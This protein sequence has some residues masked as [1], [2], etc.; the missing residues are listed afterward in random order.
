[1]WSLWLCPKVIDHIKQP[2]LYWLI[3]FSV[4]T[5]YASHLL[6]KTADSCQIWSTNFNRATKP[7][8]RLTSKTFLSTISNRK[9]WESF[10]CPI[11]RRITIFAV[12]SFPVATRDVRHLF[13]CRK[14]VDK[15]NLRRQLKNFRSSKCISFKIL[16]LVKSNLQFR[17]KI[18]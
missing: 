14:F 16:V 7:K 1:M 17:F 9:S 10:P 13:E 6:L 8:R 18:G 4:L 12:S 5:K 15:P 2:P 3:Y 11:K